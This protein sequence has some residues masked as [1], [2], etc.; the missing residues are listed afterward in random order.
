MESNKL[1]TSVSMLQKYEFWHYILRY[2]YFSLIRNKKELAKHFLKYYC[3]EDILKW[4]FILSSIN[5]DKNL[6][7][8]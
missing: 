5:Y 2:V 8:F 6:I 4:A 1:D 7:L 3:G